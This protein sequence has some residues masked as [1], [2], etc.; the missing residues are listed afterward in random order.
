MYLDG[1]MEFSPALIL[2]LIL[3]TLDCPNEAWFDGYAP[4]YE[5]LYC[6]CIFEDTLVALGTNL[7]EDPVLIDINGPLI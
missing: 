6:I 1:L 4:K 2:I 7:F 5:L 3:L